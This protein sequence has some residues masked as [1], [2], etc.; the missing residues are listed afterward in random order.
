MKVNSG[1]GSGVFMTGHKI[2]WPSLS[3]TSERQHVLELTYLRSG[4]TFCVSL[5][6]RRTCIQF[7]C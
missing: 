3:N 1:A 2:V 4:S 5:F 6:W 7:W